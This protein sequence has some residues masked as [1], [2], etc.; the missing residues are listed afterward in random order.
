[1][2]AP[3]RDF[4][5][6]LVE[7]E[8]LV[9]LVHGE[10]GEREGIEGGGVGVG[11]PVHGPDELGVGPL[12]ARGVAARP[13]H[14]AP[15][16]AGRGLAVVDERAQG[17]RDAAHRTV[18]GADLVLGG[19]RLALG[20]VAARDVLGQGADAVQ[21]TEHGVAKD[22]Q[23]GQ[24]RDHHGQPEKDQDQHRGAVQ[25]GVLQGD[26]TGQG[27]HADVLAL[28]VLDRQV[29]HGEITGNGHVAAVFGPA[30]HVRRDR[31][32]ELRVLLARHPD[33][34]VVHQRVFGRVLEIGR[35]RQ[36]GTVHV[37]GVIAALFVLEELEHVTVALEHLHRAETVARRVLDRHQAAD[38]EPAA[39]GLDAP[40]GLTVAVHVDNGLAEA[41]NVVRDVHPLPVALGLL[42]APHAGQAARV[43]QVEVELELG[44]KGLAVPGHGGSQGPAQPFA[45]GLHH[46]VALVVDV[47]L[48]GQG[49]G[50][51][52]RGH[53]AEQGRLLLGADRRFLGVLLQ[54]SRGVAD[55]H[56]RIGGPQLV[57]LPAQ[58]QI[59]AAA[60]QK[61]Q[62]D[63]RQ[64]DLEFDAHI[65][66]PMTR[67]AAPYGSPPKYI[68]KLHPA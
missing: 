43:G 4:L 6:V 3:A 24:E 31:T 46:G 33:E 64:Q 68:N 66:A 45:C 27:D 32:V 61:D 14:A 29:G 23:K 57:E 48:V 7:E 40:A 25:D 49:E 26:V 17:R 13:D 20:Q 39:P 18:D 2:V 16:L 67:N 50:L 44:P 59:A 28:I 51:D 41:R 19:H 35:G 63:S 56:L 52:H 36:Q 22:H 65:R 30:Q 38:G 15:H 10:H 47:P 42:L 60:D 34:G 62:R 5:G 21:G 53:A 8:Q 58:Q 12:V 54:G 9:A 55:Q 37:Q 1:M 11:H